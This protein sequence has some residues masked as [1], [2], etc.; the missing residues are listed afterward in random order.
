MEKIKIIYLS[1]IGRSGSTLIDLLLS[2]NQKIFSVGEVYQYQKVKEDNLMC[3]C[4][5]KFNNCDFWKQISKD[6]CKIINHVN[7]ID[8]LKMTNY[9]I[10]PISKNINF[11]NNS[12]NYELF[13]K[14]KKNNSKINFILDSSK[15]IA[16]LIELDQDK[17]LEI[18]NISII[19][20]CSA[21]ANSFSS[22]KQGKKKNYYI[23]TIKWFFVN[24]IMFKYLKKRNK[25]TLLI[26][27]EDFCKHPE[28][29][30]LRIEKYLKIKISKNYSEKIKNIEYHGLVPNRIAKIKNRKLFSGIKYDE[31]WKIELSQFKKS[32]GTI[33]E[34]ILNYIIKTN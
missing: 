9:L 30:I 29:E 5:K 22:G 34:K 32:F 10:N 27:Y 20:N 31:K 33:I 8:Y 11:K 2:T 4:G 3:S 1:G 18:Y 23:S 21:V 25:R 28:K 17:R 13:Y 16:R 26:Q 6:L 14:I 24:Y 19:R 7:L 12:S 15:D